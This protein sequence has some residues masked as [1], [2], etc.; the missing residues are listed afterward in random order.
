MRPGDIV[1]PHSDRA[2]GRCCLTF[3]LYLSPT[4]KVDYGGAFRIIGEDDKHLGIEA[5]FNSIVVFDL[6]SHK[7]HYVAD[8]R[9][10]ARDHARLTLSGWFL[11][12]DHT[13]P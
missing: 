12:P 13:E 5:R 7:K 4:W 10:A 11:S 8:I 1:K 3:V 6:V 2:K 9:P